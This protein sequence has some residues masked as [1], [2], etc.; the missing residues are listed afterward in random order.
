MARSRQLSHFCTR[1]GSD[2]AVY[3]AALVDTVTCVQELLRSIF[4]HR[5]SPEPT[6][7]R[8]IRDDEIYRRY[9]RGEST[10]NLAQH[11]GFTVQY[12]RKIIRRKNSGR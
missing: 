3:P 2:P 11:Y 9:H 10:Q 5:P 12:I 4:G 6:V 7:D 8:S 1:R